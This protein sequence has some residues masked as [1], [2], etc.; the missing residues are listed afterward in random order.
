MLGQV[1]RQSPCSDAKA[2]SGA[3]SEELAARYLRARGLS[4]LARNMRCRAGELDLVCL[5]AG[6]LAIIEVRQ[7]APSAYGGASSSVNRRKQRRILRAAL[8]FLQRRAGWRSRRLRFDVLALDGRAPGP[9]R[10]EWIKDAFRA[11]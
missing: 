2:R 3:A 7:R 5:D 9:Y 1:L 8:F 4:V 10:I 6:V 11:R